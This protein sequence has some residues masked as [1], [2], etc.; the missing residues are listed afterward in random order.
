MALDSAVLYDYQ[1]SIEEMPKKELNTSGSINVYSLIFTVVLFIMI[2]S[3]VDLVRSMVNYM[4]FYH[5]EP[6]NDPATSEENLRR[7]VKA[8]LIFF[9]LCFLFLLMVIFVR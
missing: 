6:D 4:V 5:S 8:S 9:I 7:S 1:E 3:F 2:V